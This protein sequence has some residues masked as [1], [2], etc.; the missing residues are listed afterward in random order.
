MRRGWGSW[1]GSAWRRDS[2]RGTSSA[3]STNKGWLRTWTHGPHFGTWQDSETKLAQVET[4]GEPFSPW[5]QSDSGAGCPKRLCHFY[6]AYKLTL[7]W[8]QGWTR[9][10]L[11]SLPTRI[12]L[13]TSGY[14][15]L[16]RAYPEILNVYMSRGSVLHMK[17]CETLDH[18][19]H[20]LNVLFQKTWKTPTFYRL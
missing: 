14:I 12:F 7:L 18:C 2:I 3:P 10:L 4:R 17:P 6:G 15:L 11:R 1:A 13:W 20:I 16:P 19:N 5:R 9:N 8:A